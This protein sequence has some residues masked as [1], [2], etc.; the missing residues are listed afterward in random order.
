MFLKHGDFHDAPD[1]L[2]KPNIARAHETDRNQLLRAEITTMMVRPF[3]VT[4]TRKGKAPSGTADATKVRVSGSKR[5]HDGKA[6]PD[7]VVTTTSLSAL[8]SPN[9]AG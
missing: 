6:T 2:G 9:C 1:K 4:R 3:T 7:K 8:V 5:N